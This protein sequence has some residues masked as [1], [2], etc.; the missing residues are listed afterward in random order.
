MHTLADWK[1]PDAADACVEYDFGDFA[2]MFLCCNPD[3]IADYR[4]AMAQMD[5][6][7]RATS[8]EM[9]VL[10]RRWGLC[11]PLRSRLYAGRRASTVVA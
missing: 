4:Q 1:S 9:E 8:G 6:T 2:Q 3:Y 10:A 5:G 11:F 7:G